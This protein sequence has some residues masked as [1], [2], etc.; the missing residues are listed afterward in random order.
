MR[1]KMKIK[2]ILI[3]TVY[4]GFLSSCDQ[5]ITDFVKSARPI[6]VEQPSIAADGPSAMKISPGRMSANGTNVSAVGN[7]TVTRKLMTSSNGVS[8]RMGINRS[9]ASIQ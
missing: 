4:L 3:L 5:S 9:R 8:A 7:V 1:N 2:L 6:N